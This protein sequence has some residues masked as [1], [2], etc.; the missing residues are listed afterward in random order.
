MN[1]PY[2]SKRR[3]RSQLYAYG[4]GVWMG[5]ILGYAIGTYVSNTRWEGTSIIQRAFIER[6]IQKLGTH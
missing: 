4:L 6:C 3:D 1:S 5:L 2:L